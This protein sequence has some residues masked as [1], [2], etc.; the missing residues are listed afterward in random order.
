MAVDD[1]SIKYGTAFGTTY[2][3]TTN[4]EVMDM[5]EIFLDDNYQTS[6]GTSISYRRAKKWYFRFQFRG[7][8]STMRANLLLA[9][10][11]GNPVQIV[12]ESGFL[13]T[14]T[15]TMVWLNDFD[16]TYEWPFQGSPFK[17]TMEL[18]QV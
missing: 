16:F 14:G 8:D 12:L 9:K 6:D 17:G 7:V 11:A 10:E 1:V 5:Q 4:P 3:F 2:L 15:Y 13:P 18:R